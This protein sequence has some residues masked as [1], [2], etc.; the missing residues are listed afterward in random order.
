MGVKVEGEIEPL[1]PKGIFDLPVT[2]NELKTR[3]EK[4]LQRNV[5][6]CGDN[7]PDVIRHI[8]WCTGGVTRIYSTGGRAKV[9]MHL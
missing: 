9:L 8:A 7:A 5:L 3:L 1:V 4:A 6:H 2:A